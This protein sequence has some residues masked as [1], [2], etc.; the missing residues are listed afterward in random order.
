MTPKQIAAE[1]TQTVWIDR[2]VD[3]VDR[4]VAPDLI[5]H[6]ANLPDGG[7][8]L[9]GFLRKLFGELAP[10]MSW[11]VLR[12]IAEGD[13]VAVHSLAIRAPGDRGSSVIDLYRIVGE[14]IV[15]HWD[16]SHEVPEATASGRPIY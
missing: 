8:A 9:K 16:V 14:R 6:N 7:E 12:V 13:L 2:Q 5:Q 10:Q 1:Y 15:E 11:R 4:F 3:A